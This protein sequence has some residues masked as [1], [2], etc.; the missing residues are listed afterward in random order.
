MSVFS[1]S[2]RKDV[3]LCVDNQKGL[4]WPVRP[5]LFNKHARC[6]LQFAICHLKLLVVLMAA[7]INNKRNYF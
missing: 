7:C 1:H 4:T 3:K 2:I 6:N 5:D